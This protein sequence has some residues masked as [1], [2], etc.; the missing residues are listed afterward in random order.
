MTILQ[1]ICAIRAIAVTAILCSLSLTSKCF[2]QSYD[3]TYSGGEFWLDFTGGGSYSAD[4]VWDSTYSDDDEYWGYASTAIDDFGCDGE[5]TASLSWPTGT[6]APTNVIVE[7]YCYFQSDWSSGGSGSADTGLAGEINYSSS[8]EAI[9]SGENFT[10]V[11]SSTGVTSTSVSCDP[12]ADGDAENGDVSVEYAAYSSPAG[13]T[14]NGTTADTTI[15]GQLDILV[16]Q[17]CQ[18]Q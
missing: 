6:P 18:A 12:Y 14:L 9:S 1:R 4:Y 8:I 2:A 15:P 11:S 7:Q 10:D 16:G 17:Q 3:I 5:V 13:I